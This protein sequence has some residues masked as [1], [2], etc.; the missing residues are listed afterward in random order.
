MVGVA[1][2]YFFFL[3]GFII[4]CVILIS[5]LGLIFCW[6][7][8]RLVIIILLWVSFG[9]GF[10]RYQ[11]A[12]PDYSDIS[13]IFYYNG[14]NVELLGTI[15]AVDRRLNGQK[16]TVASDSLLDKK[17]KRNVSGKILATVGLFPEYHYGD[18]VVVRCQLVKPTV[19]EDFDYGRYLSRYDI[20]ALCQRS[21]VRLLPGSKLV[22]SDLFYFWVLWSGQKLGAA[23][24]RCV[25]EPE[26]AILQ[27]MLFG[28]VRGIS[29][30]WNQKFSNLGI[31]HI[32]AIS[33]SHITIIS[34]LIISIL[35]GLGV[36]RKKSFWP[37]VAL[38]TFYVILSGAQASAVRAAI[39]GILI[40]YAQRIGRLHFMENVLA[41][42]VV[43]M[44]VA[45]PKM[46]LFDVGFQL[47]FAAVMGLVYILPIV[48]RIFN[49]WPELWQLKEML[50][51]TISAQ[52]AT[53]PIL[54]FYFHKISWSSLLAN[55]LI[56]PIIPFLMIWSLINA[57]V[58]L[59]S[60]GAG[61]LMGWV[62]WLL[63]AYWL[64]VTDLLVLIP[65]GSINLEKF[66]WPVVVI[67]YLLLIIA[68]RKIQKIY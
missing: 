40:L 56:L 59:I 38:I 30:E 67:L 24:N 21:E 58:A 54:V 57:V 35:I 18:R 7:N 15:K 1:L 14:Q 52:L 34:S 49:Y 64:K 28:N 48:K 6:S 22:D 25:S 8:K 46:L 23:L 53:L 45:N 31:T 13:K 37:A 2:S 66:S 51:T 5:G 62:S 63:V 3:D 50:L 60:T 68:V 42:T 27:G 39:M 26:V 65:Y 43:F 36:S 44:L 61:Q 55:I 11:I 19:I 9:L 12:L 41:L 29:D 20:Y 33:G 47:S 4:F 32:I 17:E 16:L 10:W